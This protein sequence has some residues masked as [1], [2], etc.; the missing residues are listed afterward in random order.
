LLKIGEESISKRFIVQEFIEGERVSVSLLSTGKKALAVS[1]N[2]QNM[3]IAGPDK[4]SSYEGGI[5]PIEHPR[6]HDAFAVAEKVVELFPGLRGYDGVDLI[7]TENAVFVV[8]V[9]PRLTTSFVGL[10]KIANFNVAE[11]LVNS[12]L[13]GKLPLKPEIQG[14]ACFSKQEMSSPTNEGYRKALNIAGV[15]SPPFP[16]LENTKSCALVMGYA[17]TSKC[18]FRIRR[19]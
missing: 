10:H 18:M 16:L 19:S 8:D 5:V 13:F 6:R 4:L 9:N 17:K 7:L 1:L 15:V 3:V 2:K 14:V 12:V 11:A